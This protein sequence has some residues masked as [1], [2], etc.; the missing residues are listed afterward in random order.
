MTRALSRIVPASALES[1]RLRRQVR[2]AAHQRAGSRATIDLESGVRW[3]RRCCRIRDI[4]STSYR[5]CTG[6]ATD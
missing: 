4:I 3:E 1:E 5:A 6:C 2:Q